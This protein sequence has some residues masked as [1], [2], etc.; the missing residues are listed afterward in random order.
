MP[1]KSAVLVNTL[2]CPWNQRIPKRR[3]EEIF[4]PDLPTQNLARARRRT[5]ECPGCGGSFPRNR[6]D[7][8]GAADSERAH[9]CTSQSLT[10][11]IQS[12]GVK[13]IHHR[14]LDFIGVGEHVG[15]IETQNVG[16]VVDAG[17]IVVPHARLDHVLPFASEPG[18]IEDLRQCAAAATRPKPP[19]T[20][21]SERRLRR[22]V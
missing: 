5:V 19:A 21:D 1:V 16:K 20:C 17:H 9:A 11:G 18:M 10:F 22:A 4:L 14:I 6:A 15:R 8:R 2:R 12:L 3:I 7:L 13:T